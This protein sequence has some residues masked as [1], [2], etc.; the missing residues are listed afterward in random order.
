[1]SYPQI[2]LRIGGGNWTKLGSQPVEVWLDRVFI[3]LGPCYDMDEE[4]KDRR[5]QYE[6]RSRLSQAEWFESVREQQEQLKSTSKCANKS[7]LIS[8]PF[9][10]V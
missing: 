9:L 2:E 10:S 8:P 3:V 4:E 7:L 5:I 6:K 1:M